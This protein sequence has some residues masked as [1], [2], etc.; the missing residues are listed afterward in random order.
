MVCTIDFAG[1]FAKHLGVKLPE[2]ACLDSLDVMNALLGKKKAKGRSHLIV[3][4]NGRGNNYGY[5]AGDWKLHRHD[6]MKTNNFQVNKLLGEQ[7]GQ[8]VPQFALFD[9]A[10][11]PAER[12][13]LAK[14]NP[15]ILKKMKGELQNFIEIG[16]S[17][18]TWYR[19]VC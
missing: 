17:R 13:N 3:Q 15:K 8:K 19:R 6:S 18:E 2:D 5:R 16:R 11:D 9:L 12:N 4:D 1:S 7:R 14:K 10:Q